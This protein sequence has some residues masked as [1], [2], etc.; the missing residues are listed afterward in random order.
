MLATWTAAGDHSAPASFY[1]ASSPR[2]LE[3][4]LGKV[5]TT[6]PAED[7]RA[8]GH[9]HDVETVLQLAACM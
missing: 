3:L 8:L 9:K 2:R 4:F 1:T 7:T 6:G 5:S